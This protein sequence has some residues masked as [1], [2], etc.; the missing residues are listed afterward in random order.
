METTF[1]GE[2]HAV[3]MQ[4]CGQPVATRSGHFRL[5]HA[6]DSYTARGLTLS[7]TVSVWDLGA[8]QGEL[9]RF[10]C[11]IPVVT[12]LMESHSYLTCLHCCSASST[13]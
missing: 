12:T 6:A 5:C 1:V 7:T 2:G 3:Q 4:E 13:Q 9:Q 10:R 8:K 11:F